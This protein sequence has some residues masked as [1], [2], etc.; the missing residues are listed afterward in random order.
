MGTSGGRGTVKECEHQYIHC[1][2]IAECLK[3][4]LCH[5]K[6]KPAIH[7]IA[8]ILTGLNSRLQVAVEMSGNLVWFGTTK[9]GGEEAVS[10]ETQ[11]PCHDTGQ[12]VSRFAGPP[13]RDLNSDPGATGKPNYLT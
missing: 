9:Q 6:G 2:N 13:C 7:D 1:L 8:T 5:A 12:N 3:R 10:P 4:A 11:V